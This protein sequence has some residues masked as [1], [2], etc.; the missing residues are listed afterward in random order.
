M[1]SI[2]EFIDSLYKG[3]NGNEKEIQELKE[4]MKTHLF[5]TVN[6]LKLK[7]NTEEESLKI[8]YERFGDNNLLATGLFKLL[9]KQRAFIK[10]T[11][12]SAII[13]LIIGLTSYVYMSQRDLKFQHEQNIL[14]KGVLDITG[15]SNDISDDKREKIE[16]LVKKYDY[17]NYI[18]LFNV[19]DNPELQKLISG[20][21]RISIVG[22][23]HYPIDVKMANILYPNNVKPITDSPDEYDLS[24][25]VASNGRWVVQYEYKKSIYRY[26]ENYSRRMVFPALRYDTPSFTYIFSDC[27]IIIGGTLFVLWLGINVLNKFKSSF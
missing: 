15:S 23:Y 14:T 8:A 19:N 25:V 5:E 3:I 20:N 1:K 21:S 17:I 18:A 24:T 2:E 4:E 26:I 22:T 7:G 6:E 10:F 16:N 13:L 9:N 27:F 12:I 11:F